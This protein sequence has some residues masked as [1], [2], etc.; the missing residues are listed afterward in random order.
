M[1]KT[2]VSRS[3][4]AISNRHVTGGGLSR[5]RAAEP[6]SP[7][8]TTAVRSM[9]VLNTTPSVEGVSVMFRLRAMLVGGGRWG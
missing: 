4:F 5:R 1:G 2:T 8:A 3:S 7:P 6:F 9:A